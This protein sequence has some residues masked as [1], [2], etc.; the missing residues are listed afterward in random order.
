VS[1]LVKLE[2]ALK[3]LVGNLLHPGIHRRVN[4]DT[5]AKEI[6]NSEVRAPAFE[7]LKD[8][9][10]DRGRRKHLVFAPRDHLNRALLG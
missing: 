7:L 6:F 8:S 1:L 2:A 9:S 10:K 3:C 4:L 5:P